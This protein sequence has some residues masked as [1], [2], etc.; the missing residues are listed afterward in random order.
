MTTATAVQ[1][2]GWCRDFADG[3][4]ATLFWLALFDR[5]S[6]AW[7]KSSG[8]RVVK[9]SSTGVALIGSLTLHDKARRLAAFGSVGSRVGEEGCDP[10]VDQREL[11]STLLSRV[12]AQEEARERRRRRQA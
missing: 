1:M 11:A 2:D 9:S 4:S 3:A 8:Q 12:P 5:T 7:R 6:H 10:R